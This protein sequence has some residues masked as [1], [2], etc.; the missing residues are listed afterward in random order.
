MT[1]FLCCSQVSPSETISVIQ[2]ASQKATTTINGKPSIFKMVLPSEDWDTRRLTVA[3]E[4]KW[5]EVIKAVS[6]C[7]NLI[8]NAWRAQITPKFKHLYCIFTVLD[9]KLRKHGNSICIC[10]S[11][12]YIGWLSLIWENKLQTPMRVLGLGFVYNQQALYLCAV[13]S[14]LRIQKLLSVDVTT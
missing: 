12:D 13:F 10:S 4:V 2:R 8:S 3:T 14:T 5:C 1:N 6:F 7:S 11:L 9:W